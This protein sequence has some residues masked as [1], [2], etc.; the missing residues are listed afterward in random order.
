M[1]ETKEKLTEEQA[2]QAIADQVDEFKKFMK[3]DEQSK[4]DLQ[5]V[6]TLVEE[7]KVN[8]DSWNSK[9]VS[10]AIDSINKKNESLHKQIIE[11]QEKAAQEIENGVG[12]KRAGGADRKQIESFVKTLFPNG[13]DKDKS[14]YAKFELKD[15]ETFGAATFVSGSNRAVVTGSF[16]DPTL[17]EKRR[18]KNLITDYFNIRPINVP[19]IFYVEKVEVGAPDNTA[20]TGGADWI[21]CGEAKPLR[22]FRINT[23]QTE[24]KKLAIF[25][26]VDDCLL[27]DVDSFERWLRDDFKA[28]MAETYNDGLLFGNPSTHPKKPIGLTLNAKAF[29]PTTAFNASIIDANYIDA[30]IAAIALMNSKYES[31]AI[32]FVSTDVYYRIHALKSSDGK[33]LNNSLVY[34]NNLGQ[35]FIAGVLVVPQDNIASGSLLLVGA[36]PGFKIYNYGGV[37]FESGLNG[38]DFREDKTS[39][40]AWQRVIS[41]IPADRRW[42]VIY[43]TW[44]NIISAIDAPA[45]APDA[46][47]GSGTD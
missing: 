3:D 10:D 15:A 32:A 28:E 6:K 35:L 14:A 26:T 9:Q 11:L 34:I 40:R 20:D 45:P 33:W 23:V 47:G 42:S 27:Q 25:S 1:A 29:T 18:A 30:I 19:T 13:K 39:Y 43:D 46:G 22:S 16:T 8:L 41:Y 44:N 24:A 12:S 5:S 21:N 7:L 31:A 37:E 4:K 2:L 17:Y 38:S 36:D